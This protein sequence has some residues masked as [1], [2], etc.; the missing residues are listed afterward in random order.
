MYTTSNQQDVAVA[1]KPGGD[2]LAVWMSE[3]QD[4]DGLSVY[5]RRFAA[6]P[7][8]IFRDDFEANN[9]AAWSAARPTAGTS[10]P[11]AWPA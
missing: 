5:G 7:D 3:S 4:G 9:L 8:L 6:D 2:F 11:P 10:A 1:S